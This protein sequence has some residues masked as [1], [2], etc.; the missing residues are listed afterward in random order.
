MR[1]YVWLFVIAPAFLLAAGCGG[2]RPPSYVPVKGEVTMNGKPL[3]D[4]TITFNTDGRPPV[5][6]NIYEG[7]YSG[8]AMVGTNRISISAK[9]KGTGATNARVDEGAKARMAGEQKMREMQGGPQA[10][11]V[12]PGEDIIPPDYGSATKQ[13]RDVVQG[14]ENKFDFDIRLKK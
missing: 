7:K 12:E 4:A 13:V 14:A 2:D 5:L 11:P 1:R 3:D 10:A 9:R 6:I 8:Q